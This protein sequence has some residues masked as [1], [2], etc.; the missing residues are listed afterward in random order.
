MSKKWSWVFGILTAAA[1][2]LGVIFFAVTQQLSGRD[3][4]VLGIGGLFGATAA[5]LVA[6]FVFHA[7]ARAK[8][9]ASDMSIAETYA[10]SETARLDEES[11]SRL[12]VERRAAEAEQVRRDRAAEVALVEERTRLLTALPTRGERLNELKDEIM[13][14]NVNIADANGRYNV[15]MAQARDVA[16]HGFNDMAYENQAAARTW[17][18]A[19]ARFEEKLPEL[20]ADRDRLT[21][22][23][24]E[25][26][27]TE[28]KHLRGLD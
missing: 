13:Q 12:S 6:T 11:R 19:R 3:W 15:G 10:A 25:D 20:E 17:E 9:F 24:D 4:A 5:A 22:M 2:V 16:N 21:A 1:F 27:L 26:Y 18:I 8:K 23:T 28:Q 7:D 14:L